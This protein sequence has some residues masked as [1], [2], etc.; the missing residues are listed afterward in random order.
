MTSESDLS[1]ARS[2]AQLILDLAEDDV[3]KIFFQ[4]TMRRNLARTVRHL[5]RLVQSGGDDRKLG[6]SALQ[7]LGFGAHN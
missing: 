3:A 6:E 7:R 2:E 5:D 1:E 4:Q